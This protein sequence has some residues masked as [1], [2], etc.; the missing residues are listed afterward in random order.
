[1]PITI[2]SHA[3]VWGIAAIAGFTSLGVAAG[4]ATASD[5]AASATSSAQAPQSSGYPIH[6]AEY[7]DRL[8]AAYGIGDDV[9]INHL[10]TRTVVDALA[11]HSDDHTKR[12]HRTSADSGKGYTWVSYTNLRTHEVMTLTV[13]NAIAAEGIGDAVREVEFVS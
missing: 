7:A 10:A 13:R 1:M 2:R 6:A 11:E 5:D 3:A 8:V 12:W 4:P 9:M